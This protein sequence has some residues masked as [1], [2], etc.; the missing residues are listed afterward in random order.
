MQRTSSYSKD[1]QEQET[2]LRNQLEAERQTFEENSFK[3]LKILQQKDET[4]VNLQKLLNNERVQH[5]AAKNA[6][7]QANTEL[8]SKRSDISTS[9]S[10]F[11]PQ[12]LEQQ[13]SKLVLEAQQLRERCIDQSE[14]I[15]V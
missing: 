10:K 4:I 8:N 2:L 5:L 13:N 1:K 15:Q 6:L 14:Q 7:L 11:S 3:A 9:S 12:E